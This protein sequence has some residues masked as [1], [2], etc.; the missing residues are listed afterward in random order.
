MVDFNNEEDIRKMLQSAYKPVV[1]SPELK[2]QLLEHFK[3]EASG[4]SFSTSRPL[5]GRPR[6]WIPVVLALISGAIG[7]GAWLSLNIVP[8]LLR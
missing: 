7:Y 3:A 5:R 6:A 2:E 4:A 8:K 1:M